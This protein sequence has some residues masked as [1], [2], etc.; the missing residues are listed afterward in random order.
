[1][2]TS[3]AS[4]PT[5]D[6]SPGVVTF[7][8]RGEAALDELVGRLVAGCDGTTES[9][10][11]VLEQV[12]GADVD[13]LAAA[14]AAPAQPLT[15]ARS[16][17]ADPTNTVED[18]EVDEVVPGET[19]DAAARRRLGVRVPGQVSDVPVVRRQDPGSQR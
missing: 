15:A 3:P 8:A 2:S 4:G 9:I 18:V 17:R 19:P 11:A 10:T 13:V 7:T 6:R 12:L 14:L 1:M 16:D 5:P